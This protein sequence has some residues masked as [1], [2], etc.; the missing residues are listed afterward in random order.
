MRSS[1]LPRMMR[2]ALPVLAAAMALAA[3][4]ALPRRH[5]TESSLEAPSAAPSSSAATRPE[6]TRTA[7]Q[8]P[9]E[10]PEAAP[11]KLEAMSPTFRNSTLLIAIRKAGFVCD[12]VAAANRTGPRVWVASCQD[13]NG[14]EISVDDDDSLVPRPIV[15]YFDG[16]T[17]S[18]FP[19]S[20]RPLPE[21]ELP[22]R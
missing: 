8:E 20:D 1:P 14:Y 10:P 13:L 17:P 15:H 6:N 3:Y 16:L 21:R 2:A 19:P 22:R 12:D 11:G 5:P 7:L 4:F 18:P 9:K